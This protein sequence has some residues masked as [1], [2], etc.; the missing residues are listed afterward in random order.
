MM[1]MTQRVKVKA[2]SRMSMTRR[3][4]VKIPHDLQSRILGES[5]KTRLCLTKPLKSCVR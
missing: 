2:K 1:S 4:K 5:R 3:V